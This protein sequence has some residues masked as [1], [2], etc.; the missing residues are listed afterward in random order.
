[1]GVSSLVPSCLL[2]DFILPRWIHTK[3]RVIGERT[4]RIEVLPVR[5][6]P[7]R[8]DIALRRPEIQ[9]S[10]TDQIVEVMFE[11]VLH[12]CIP[13]TGSIRLRPEVADIAGS[14]ERR[15][16]QI[17]YFVVSRAWIP[18]PILS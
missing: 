4:I 8:S 18:N 13:F 11:R 12:V 5:R 17:I 14:A 16:D 10:G 15:G 1:M 2:C 3:A 6:N 9:S 7:I